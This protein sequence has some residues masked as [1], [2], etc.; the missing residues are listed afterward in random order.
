[1]W[2]KK[3]NKTI[4][5]FNNI[6]T[7]FESKQ[8]EYYLQ[9]EALQYRENFVLNNIK[10]MLEQNIPIKDYLY[11]IINENSINKYT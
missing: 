8:N 4:P 5:Y 11:T 7:L 9:E 1:M 2:N 6:T 10:N 3:F